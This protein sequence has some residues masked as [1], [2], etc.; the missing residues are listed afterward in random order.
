MSFRIV[1]EKFRTFYE[2]L[3]ND[4]FSLDEMVALIDTS[5]PGVADEF[6]LGKVETIFSAPESVYEPKGLNKVIAGYEDPNGYSDEVYEKQF[7]TAEGGTVRLFAHPK[8]D[9]KWNDDDKS[10]IDFLL[11]V[12]YLSCSRLRL[13]SLMQQTQ[14]IDMLTGSLNMMGFQRKVDELY[15]KNQLSEYASV[16]ANIKNFKYINQQ[17]GSNNGDYILKQYSMAVRNFLG[18][19]GLFC[20]LGGDNFVT[21]VKKYCLLRYIAFVTGMPVTVD[22]KGQKEDVRIDFKSGVFP[23]LPDSDPFLCFHCL[24]GGSSLS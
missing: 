18:E 4:V 11:E 7:N 19:N 6:H 23:I 5:L 12:L 8:M 1:S 14:N 9:W 16:F 20:R 24:S 15:A 10:D 2:T 22:N 17:F 21:L 3:N 13:L